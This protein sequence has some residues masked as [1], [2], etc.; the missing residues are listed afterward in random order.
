MKRYKKKLQIDVL[1]LDIEN[2]DSINIEAELTIFDGK[3]QTHI[4]FY[5]SRSY[6]KNKSGEKKTGW[7]L[8]A[9]NQRDHMYKQSALFPSDLK[10]TAWENGVVMA[11]ISENIESLMYLTGLDRNIILK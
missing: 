10:T 1:E 9:F 6:C 2:K 5:I 8:E 3:R 4:K 7:R 11:W